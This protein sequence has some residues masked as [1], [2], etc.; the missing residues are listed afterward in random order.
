M[1]RFPLPDHP[2]K[3]NRLLLNVTAALVTVPF[4]GALLFIG[5]L[6][7]GIVLAVILIGFGTWGFRRRK[8]ELRG[9]EVQR[10]EAVLAHAEL[11][12]RR[13]RYARENGHS[14]QET[15][16]E[17]ALGFGR[18]EQRIPE[19][20]KE[21]EGGATMGERVKE[22]PH[23]EKLVGV[24]RHAGELVAEG[25]VRMRRE[26]LD[27]TVFDLEVID[28]HDLE[29]LVTCMK[30]AVALE[31]S[32]D[33]M[34]VWSVELPHALPYVSSAYAWD[35]R[36]GPLEAY[37]EGEE[38][39]ERRT[40]NKELADFLLSLP[41]VRFDA[42]SDT[43]HPWFIDGNRLMACARGN[44]GVDP[45]TLEDTAARLARLAAGL[46]W[47]ALRRFTLTDPQDERRA[48]RIRW[49]QRWYGSPAG[50]PSARVLW[51]ERRITHAG[52]RAFM[53]ADDIDQ[54]LS[55]A[56]ART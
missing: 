9:L 31:V 34:T 10:A 41:A 23:L 5:F 54:G 48:S 26:G 47:T 37:V 29:G 46:P 27:V 33:Y 18:I 44:E 32:K 36:R 45:R 16:A 21:W 25:V 40:E 15:C 39:L 42:L 55:P 53:P 52:L 6:A 43:P 28:H 7:G 22:A 50:S 3:T 11:L 35:G 12:E 1:H 24:A 17:S 19:D 4:L 13:E 51:E 8:A 14:Y 30:P 56:A 2:L 38:R 20:R 49:T